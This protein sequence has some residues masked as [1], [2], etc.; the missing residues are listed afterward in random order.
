P[1]RRFSQPLRPAEDCWSV[2]NDI[3]KK[4][5]D[6]FLDGLVRVSMQAYLQGKATAN[7]GEPVPLARPGGVA[8][9]QRAFEHLRRLAQCPGHTESLGA[10][11]RRHY[12]TTQFSYLPA[13][14]VRQPHPARLRPLTGV[15]G[16]CFL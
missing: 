2:E 8:C 15:S 10:Q 6:H 5:R 4:D 1:A 11:W 13:P 14:P 16:W 7:R 3:L 12:S 9:Q